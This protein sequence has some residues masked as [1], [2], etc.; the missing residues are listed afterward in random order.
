MPKPNS[1]EGRRIYALQAAPP[2]MF[3]RLEVGE[4]D[5]TEVVVDEDV[6]GIS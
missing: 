3:N 5:A 1:K 2:T 6:K 4:D